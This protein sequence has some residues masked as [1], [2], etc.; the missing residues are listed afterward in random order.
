VGY[1]TREPFEFSAGVENITGK[2]R[3]E[4]TSDDLFVPRTSIGR[5]VYGKITLRF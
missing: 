4:H 2:K 3:V 5:T 1:R